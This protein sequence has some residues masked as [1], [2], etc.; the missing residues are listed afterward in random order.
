LTVSLF[1]L[2]GGLAVWGMQVN[3]SS[4]E[5]NVPPME[6]SEICGSV[7][8]RIGAAF[9]RFEKN[10]NGFYSTWGQQYWERVP[11]QIL[12]SEGTAKIWCLCVWKH[13]TWAVMIMVIRT[14]RYS[15]VCFRVYDRLRMR[16][17]LPFLH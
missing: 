5:K 17:P 4:G 10:N 3:F 15:V 2:V 7:S 12:D 13:Y 9:D 16:I 11:L 6:S 8:S 1:E 14:V